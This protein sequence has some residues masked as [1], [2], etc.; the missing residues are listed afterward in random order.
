MPYAAPLK[1]MLFV[2]TDLAGLSAVNALPGH[3]DATLDTAEAVL[4]EN[5]KFCSAVVAPL[6]G[7]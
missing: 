1:D 5:A 4:H 3:E 7:R 6:N 2:M